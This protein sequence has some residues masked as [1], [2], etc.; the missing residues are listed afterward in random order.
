MDL[1]DDPISLIRFNYGAGKLAVD[2]KHPDLNAIGRAVLDLGEI[3]YI[4]PRLIRRSGVE[5]V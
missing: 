3:K 1:H 5:C 4:V 2:E